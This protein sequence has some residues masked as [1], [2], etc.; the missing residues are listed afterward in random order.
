M[1]FK[2]FEALKGR[3]PSTMGAAHGT[4]SLTPDQKNEIH[5]ITHYNSSYIGACSFV[6]RKI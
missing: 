1:M 5:K 3:N 4:K 2:K 6:H